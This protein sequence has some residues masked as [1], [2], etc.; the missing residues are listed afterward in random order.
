M[1]VLGGQ[2]SDVP[3]ASHQAIR[4]VDVTRNARNLG[5]ADNLGVQYQF[6]VNASGEGY[7]EW[8]DDA[9]LSIW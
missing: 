7:Y 2:R 5:W 4:P 1:R 3:P 6:D 8:V 9:T